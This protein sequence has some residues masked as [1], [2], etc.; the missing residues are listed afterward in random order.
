MRLPSGRVLR[1]EFP[2][3]ATLNDV[4]GF[5]G[6][7]DDKHSAANMTLVQVRHVDRDLCMHVL[8]F[9]CSLFLV[10]NTHQ[11]KVKGRWSPSDFALPRLSW[12]SSL[13][14]ATTRPARKGAFS[15]TPSGHLPSSAWERVQRSVRSQCRSPMMMRKRRRPGLVPIPMGR[16]MVWDMGTC[17]FHCTVVVAS[18]GH[19]VGMATGVVGVVS[20]EEVAAGTSTLVVVGVATSEEVEM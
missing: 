3:S 13:A 2:S 4:I 18:A 20:Q 16:M 6:S 12:W 15:A 17:P 9:Y 14:A 1:R 19:L 7:S 8:H 11:P 5:V 10:T